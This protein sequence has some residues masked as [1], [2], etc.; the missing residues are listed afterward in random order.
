MRI[1][2]LRATNFRGWAELDLKQQGHVLA[3]GEPRAGRTDLVAALARV[4]DPRSTRLS[5][6]V[7]DIHQRKAATGAQQ[8]GSVDCGGEPDDSGA[9]AVAETQAAE[10]GVGAGEVQTVRAPFAEV[11]VTLSELGP[12]VEQEALGALEPL[13]GDL[14]VDESGNAQP[15]AELGLRVAYR[16]TYDSSADA[17]EHLV[18]YPAVSNPAAGQFARVPTTVR[19]L[20]PVIFLDTT[21]P[22]QLRAEGLLRRLLNDHDPDAVADALRTLETQVVDAAGTLSATPVVAQLLDAIL[23]PTGPARRAGDR[24]LTSG[25]VQFS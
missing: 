20:L 17:L 15:E 16:I 1:T 22:L 21:R 10:G 12:D 18:Y 19:L 3:L 14:Q 24:P 23:S 8:P 5:P 6:V 2:R 11:E 9:G 13:T 7:T 4:L 25:D